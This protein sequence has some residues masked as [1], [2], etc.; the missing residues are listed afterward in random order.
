MPPD[1]GG[2]REQWQCVPNKTRLGCESDPPVGLGGTWQGSGTTCDPNP[3]PWPYPGPGVDCFDPVEVDYIGEPVL[4]EDAT[5]CVYKPMYADTCIAPYDEGDD[6][7][8][9]ITTTESQEIAIEL[10]PQGEPGT[11]IALYSECPPTDKNCLGQSTGD[12]GEAHGF[13]LM[14]APGTYYVM[15][16]SAQGC[17]ANF[18]FGIAPGLYCPA[19]LSGDG[20]VEAFDLA[21][22]LGDWGECPEPCVPG[23][24]ASTC[25]ADLSGDCIVEAFDL[26]QLLGD[27]GPCP[28]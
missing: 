8:Y 20:V 6:I 12:T 28:E 10:D 16:D 4:Y 15:V 26:A 1:R 2:D 24:P 3:C 5:T 18:E 7:H 19:D 25:A 11:G 9:Q 21:I 17:I 23:P 13:E 14:L 22:L 27:W